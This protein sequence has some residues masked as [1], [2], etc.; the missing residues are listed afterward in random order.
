MKKLAI[1]VS[2]PVPY[3]VPIYRLLHER[4]KIAVEVF[5]L[6]DCF[7]TDNWFDKSIS[8]PFWPFIHDQDVMDGYKS[9]FI[10]NLALNKF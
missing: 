10:K 9:R 5:Y 4:N 6:W 2:H 3:H 8:E 1:I 7:E